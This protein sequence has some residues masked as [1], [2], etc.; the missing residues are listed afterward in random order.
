MK[1]SYVFILRATTEMCIV[2]GTGST[3]RIFNK[4]LVKHNRQ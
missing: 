2:D 3:N 4:T 1:V